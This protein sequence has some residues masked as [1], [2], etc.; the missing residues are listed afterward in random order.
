MLPTRQPYLQFGA[1]TV[2]IS[3]IGPPNHPDVLA[4]RKADDIQI[5]EGR[6]AD[7]ISGI[8]LRR[9]LQR[10]LCLPNQFHSLDLSP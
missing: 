6:V 7:S 3:S 8:L 1:L 5:V 2:P 9:R 4:K 10:T